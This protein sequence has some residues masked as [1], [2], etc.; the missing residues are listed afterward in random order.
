VLK[1]FGGRPGDA[2]L[3]ML[4]LAIL[5]AVYYAFVGM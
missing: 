3:V 1:V 2:G 5:L 4:F